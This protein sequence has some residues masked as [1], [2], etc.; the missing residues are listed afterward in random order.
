MGIFKILKNRAS[1]SIFGISAIKKMAKILH[2]CKFFHFDLNL[3]YHKIKT[4]TNFENPNS[5]SLDLH[6]I[7]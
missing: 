7:M 2:F 4:R 6:L 3:D 1:R 5:K